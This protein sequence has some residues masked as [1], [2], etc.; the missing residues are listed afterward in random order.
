MADLQYYSAE[1]R[2]E[3]ARNYFKEVEGIDKQTR[4]VILNSINSLFSVYKQ[5]TRSR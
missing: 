3:R 4:T 2:L 5:S 1:A